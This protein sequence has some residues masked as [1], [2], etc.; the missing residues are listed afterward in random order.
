[1]A[2]FAEMQHSIRKESLF[3][4]NNDNG[5][6]SSKLCHTKQ[7]NCKEYNNS[8]MVIFINTP[9]LLLMGGHTIRFI[10]S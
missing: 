2:E 1:M 3:E 7:S 4:I 10:M 6:K 8:H 9:G 5:V